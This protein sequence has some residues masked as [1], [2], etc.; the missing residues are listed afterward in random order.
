MSKT[1]LNVLNVAHGQ[2]EDGPYWAKIQTLSD[3]LESRRGFHGQQVITFSVDGENAKKVAEAVTQVAPSPV[4]FLTSLRVT[5]G[6]PV[7]IISGLA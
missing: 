2:I 1:T 7:M 4:D 6:K 3:E 5:G